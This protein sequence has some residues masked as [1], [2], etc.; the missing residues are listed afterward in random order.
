VIG[1]RRT[2][3]HSEQVALELAA[4]EASVPTPDAGV[5]LAL[6]VASDADVR[7]YVSD[8]LR[9]DPSLDVVAT[10]SVASALDQAARHTPRVLIAA[11]AERAVLR[12]LPGVPAV[13][14]SDEVPP[15]ETA[16]AR[17]LATLVVLRGAFRVERLLEVVASLLAR[18]DGD[19]G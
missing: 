5:P 12:H 11:H 6:V 1:P 14:L 8:S 10:G 16:D 4:L 13:L 2:P 19:P 15:A 18:T 17:R 7:S 9:Q 3:E